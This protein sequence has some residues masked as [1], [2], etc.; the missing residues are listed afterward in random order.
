MSL[1]TPSRYDRRT[2]TLHWTTAALILFMRGGAHA[3][4]WFPKGPE[5]VD[6]RSVHIV[7]GA[8]LVCLTL[9]RL[10]WRTTG[11]TRIAEPLSP[12]VRIAKGVHYALYAL[13]GATLGLGLFNTWLRGDD[14]F[15]LT[16]IP[17]FG[18]YA[19]PARHA[20]VE[21]I[22]GWHEFGANAILILAGIHAAAA[23]YHRLVLRDDVLG[24]MGVR[25]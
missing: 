6:A 20:F 8:A 21:N 15:G 16:H 10:F 19:K 25:V 24:R 2:I 7:V 22:T 17:A 9:Y 11:G 5:R 13:V 12:L 23:L 18:D 14:L 3:I 4:D 1:T